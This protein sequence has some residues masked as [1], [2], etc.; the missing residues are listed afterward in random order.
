MVDGVSRPADGRACTR[1][2]QRPDRYILCERYQQIFFVPMMAYVFGF[3]EAKVL[4]LFLKTNED[5]KICT[6]AC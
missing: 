3:L 1:P 6:H 5:H 4:F 2:I